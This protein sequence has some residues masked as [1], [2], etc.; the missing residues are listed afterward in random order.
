MSNIPFV[1]R[2]EILVIIHVFLNAVTVSSPIANH[3]K[4]CFALIIGDPEVVSFGKNRDALDSS[5]PSR[6]T[7]PGSPQ[8]LAVVGRDRSAMHTCVGLY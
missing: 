3:W 1:T 6:L 5:V 4:I 7:S 2:D 8:R